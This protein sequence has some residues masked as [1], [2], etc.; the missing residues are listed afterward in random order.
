MNKYVL[1]EQLTQYAHNYPAEARIA[2][3][4][5]QTIK[6]EPRC[7]E[8]QNS[9][10]HFTASAWVVNEQRNSTLLTLHRKLDL[11]LQLGGHTDGAEDMIETARREAQEESGLQEFNLVTPAIL[12]IDIHLIPAYKNDLEHYHYDVRYL[13]VADDQQPLNISH[14]SKE[15]AWWEFG[16][17]DQISTERTKLLRMAEKTR[18]IN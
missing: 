10:V 16:H 9:K 3:Q 15:L 8:R 2:D 4:M 14:E 13:F 11:W 7:F 1:I 17:L 5:I 12:D 6:T 18:T